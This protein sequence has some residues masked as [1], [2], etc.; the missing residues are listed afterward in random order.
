MLLRQALERGSLRI[1]KF[2]PNEEIERT[3]V[4]IDSLRCLIYKFLT[5]SLSSRCRELKNVEREATSAVKAWDVMI[6]KAR[7]PSS[8]QRE[9]PAILDRD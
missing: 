1:L 3:L 7:S 8:G 9:F 5:E 4:S 2:I 6:V